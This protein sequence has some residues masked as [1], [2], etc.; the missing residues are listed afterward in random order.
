MFSAI[1]LGFHFWQLSKGLT[2]IEYHQWCQMKA[3][4]HHLGVPFH[5]THEFD[6]GCWNNWKQMFGKDWFFWCIPT[7]PW[8]IEDGYKYEI[9][10]ENQEEVIEFNQK[11]H[12]KRQEIWQQQQH[13]LSTS[14]Y[15]NDIN[16]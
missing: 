4:G 12:K 9:N 1:H 8:L 2:S 10:Y 6:F 14:R 5:N 3:M 7:N 11:I 15:Y 16:A 13:G